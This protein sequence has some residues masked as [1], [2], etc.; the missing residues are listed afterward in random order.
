MSL[1]QE[2]MTLKEAEKIAKKLT[3][4]EIFIQDEEE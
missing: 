4:E 1:D 2:F 3:I